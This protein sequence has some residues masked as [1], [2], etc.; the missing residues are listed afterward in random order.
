MNPRKE[1][2]QLFMAQHGFGWVGGIL[3]GGTAVPA[4]VQEKEFGRTL[5]EA[6]VCSTLAMRWWVR[7]GVVVSKSV[8]GWYCHT[9]HVAVPV[10]VNLVVVD[11]MYPWQIV[12]DSRP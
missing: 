2:I 8:V 5:R 11:D 9:S 4:R 6:K 1:V 7:S 10:V 12:A 3:I